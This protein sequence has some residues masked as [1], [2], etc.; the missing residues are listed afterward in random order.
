[1]NA[2]DTV[3][4]QQIAEMTIAA[5][6]ANNPAKKSAATRSLN[7]YVTRRVN[8]GGNEI[9]VRA[10]ITGLVNKLRNNNS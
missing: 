1:M 8:E 6:R 5:E 2:T 4:A 3:T 7:A 9:R 10:A